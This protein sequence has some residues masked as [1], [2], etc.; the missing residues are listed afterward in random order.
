MSKVPTHRISSDQLERASNK[1]RSEVEMD[2]TKKS[3]RSDK[4]RDILIFD[5]MGSTTK[6]N[7]QGKP[8]K[9]ALLRGAS[10]KLFTMLFRTKANYQDVYNIFRTN[11]MSSK[12][13]AEA[14]S[15]VKTFSEQNKLSGISAQAVQHEINQF[16]STSKN[17]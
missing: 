3:G 8:V 9:G 7:S 15:N 1:A 11:G 5:R 10:S 16:K 17:E 6:I 2:L 4:S 14:L 12:E 13:A